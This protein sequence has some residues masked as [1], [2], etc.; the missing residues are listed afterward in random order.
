MIGGILLLVC[1]AIFGVGFLIGLLAF[2][3]SQKRT[4]YAIISGITAVIVT[5]GILFAGCIVLINQAS[6]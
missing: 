4:A 1:G 2:A 5:V 6:H 3:H